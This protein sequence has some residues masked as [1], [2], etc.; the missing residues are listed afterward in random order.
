MHKAIL[1]V[2][3]ISVMIGERV[4]LYPISLELL[5]GQK[6]AVAGETGSG[7]STLLKAIA[8][9]QNLKSGAVYLQGERVEEAWE[10][11]IPG[12]RKIAYL[13]QHF[14][15]RNNYRVHE[16]LS[17]AEKVTKQEAAEIY[18][19]CQIDHLLNRKTDQLS[20]GE[21]Q[22]IAMARLLVGAPVLFLL[23]EPFSNL[24]ALH[25]Q[26]MKQVMLDLGKAMQINWVL[27]SHDPGDWLSW[28]DELL[29]LREGKQLQKGAPA[30]LFYAPK[31]EYTAGLLGAYSELNTREWEQLSGERL[32]VPK[33][34]RPAQLQLSTVNT[35]PL[36]G[37]V[38]E[39][40]F[41][42]YGYLLT[43]ELE[44]GSRIKLFHQEAFQR[45]SAVG[46]Q[47]R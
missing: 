13:S 42:G 5:P 3:E 35:A 40:E 41:V 20:G 28:A 16:I 19:L 43:I 18:R 2:Q 37:Y 6:L 29:I 4:V 36:K 46:V 21:R 34:I 9:L 22:R 23:D 15:L 30:S 14:E 12:H 44:S 38:K 45:D 27:V 26:T 47:L 1:E 33:I 32:E 8:G 31:D 10:K 24:D 7:K 25:K 11:L 17:Y 39:T